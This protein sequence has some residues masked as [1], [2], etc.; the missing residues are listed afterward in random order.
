[1]GQKRVF[2]CQEC[3]HKAPRWMGRCPGCGSWNSFVEEEVNVRGRIMMD[4]SSGREAP[5]PITEIIPLQEERFSAGLPELDRVMGGGIVPGSLILLGGDPGIGKSTI[6]LQVA[7]NIGARAGKVLYVSGEESLS[8]IKLRADRLGVWEERVYLVAE[9]EI[10]VVERY[11]R[12]L[13]PRLVII[14]SIQTMFHP[15]V[16]SAPGSVTQVRE[17][18]FR[19][20]KV[21]KSSLIS[22]VIVGHVTK[23]GM[24][25][26][27]KVLEHMV[28]VVL[29]LE[30]ERH[31]GYRLLRGVK[32]RFGST[33]EVGVFEMR[34]SGLAQVSN[35]SSLFMMA[36]S[37]EVPGAVVVPT[38]EGSRPLL[39]EIQALVCPSAFGVPRRMTTG[40][41]PGRAALI[42]AVLEKRLGM[43]MGTHDAYINVVGGVK[44]YEPAADL[45]I[46][47][48]LASSFRDRPVEWGLA[49]MGEIGLT[50]EIRSV[51]GVERRVSEARQLG[52]RHCL[53][54]SADAGLVKISGI[55]VEGVRTVADAIERALKV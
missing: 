17:C 14:D 29:Y 7:G 39:V 32:N 23:E 27:P 28:D 37:E 41:D 50:G 25:A 22:V 43:Q 12:E 26:G 55:K 30:G 13:T 52:F 44:V 40:V 45:G 16:S 51:P 1:M 35:P 8:Q 3:G 36:H 21:A 54:P 9:T 15:E 47:I 4:S 42:M 24:L 2:F 5:R 49:V 6:L 38:M 10:T 53:V 33:N 18:T 20:M 34:S 19:L 48:S 31:Q 46:A 11:I